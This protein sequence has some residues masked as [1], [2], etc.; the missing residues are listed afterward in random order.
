MALQVAKRGTAGFPNDQTDPRR[1]SQ[2]H[3]EMTPEIHSGCEYRAQRRPLCWG[4]RSSHGWS[5]LPD[6][7]VE[8]GPRTAPSR[9]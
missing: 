7:I 8:Q 2:I 4:G 3:C 1:G 9:A 6:G 5:R